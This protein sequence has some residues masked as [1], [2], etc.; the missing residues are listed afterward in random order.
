M[1]ADISFLQFSKDD[2]NTSTDVYRDY[3]YYIANGNMR[4]YKEIV[5]DRGKK[6]GQSYYN[7]VIDLIA[8]VEKLRSALELSGN[9]MC[10]VLLAL[11]VHDMNKIPP[12][13][14]RPDG[15][16]ASYVNA[17]TQENIERELERLGTER[18][19]PEWRSYLLDITLLAHFHQESATGTV[20]TIDQRKIQQYILP[21][22]RLKGPLKFLMKAAD[23]ADNSHS[24]DQC[25]RDEAHIRDKLLQ[26]IN[27]AM[28]ERQYR[29]FGHR[30]A[31]LRGLFTNVMHNNLVKFFQVRYGKDAC[32]DLLY[33]PE[34]VNYL[35]DKNIALDWSDETLCAVATRIQ[36]HLAAIQLEDIAQFIKARPAG[37]VV[38]DAA[39]ASGAT[40]EQLF[41]V[42]VNTVLRKQYKA[43]WRTQRDTN[44]RTDLEEALSHA[45]TGVQL[46]EQVAAFLQQHPQLI[47][48]DEEVLKR[49]EFASAYR[50]FLEDHRADQLKTIKGDT[51]TRLYRLFKLPEERYALYGLIDPFRRGYFLAKDLPTLNIDVMKDMVLTDLSALEEEVQAKKAA[52]QIQKTNSTSNK[53]HRAIPDTPAS[54]PYIVDYLRRNVEVWETPLGQQTLSKPVGLVQFGD[55]LRQY[56]N[57]KRLHEQCCYCGSPLKAGEWM[58]AQVPP[59]IGVQSFSNRLEAGWLRDPKRNVCD[60]CRMQFI[61]EKLAW[62]NHGDKQGGK[63]ST[64]Y[65]HLFPYAFFTQ[66]TLSSWWSSIQ[67]LR[68]SDHRA[69]LLDTKAYFRT[70]TATQNEPPVQGYRTGINGLGLPALSETLSNTPVLPIVAPGEN[71]GLQFLLALEEAVVL[72][73]W[74]ECRVLLS[75]S[76]IPLLNLAH[77]YIESKPVVLMVEGMPRTMNWLL[78]TTSLDT[79]GMNVLLKKLSVLHQLADKLYYTG[80]DFDTLP[81]DF[82][83]TAGDDP[84]A[85]FKLA[86][87]LIEKKVAHEKATAAL[88]PEQKALAL[89]RQLAPMLHEL[90]HM[91]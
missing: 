78:P 84:L 35:L 12:Y 32:I 88:S 90:M 45:K 41:T 47:A 22:I 46:K 3:L 71:Y 2:D 13:N 28:P 85:V 82:S 42:I 4:T 81:Y 21:S 67:S 8:V 77:E 91:S 72:A 23:V 83:M 39:L 26:H 54:I 63:Q 37:I 73:R 57:A 76:P 65:L 64:F 66:P 80:G 31:E 68:D 70:W 29:F 25:N 16:D 30:L 11:T 14:K 50:K 27:A 86:D 6:Q 58:S 43:E 49:G 60:A 24:G 59:N 61:L 19:F 56:A 17:A 40:V 34:G 7:H 15:G 51:W 55:T 79:S 44:A 5:H 48:S 38:D 75:R 36:Q 10:C 33:Y 89:R 52:V 18:F 69:F 20:L 62:R 9:E 87:R 74:F 1:P 53:G